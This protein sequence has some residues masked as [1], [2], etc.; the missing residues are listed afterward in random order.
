MLNP[1]PPS[2]LAWLIPVNPQSTTAFRSAARCGCGRCPLASTTSSKGTST[3]SRKRRALSCSAAS[4]ALRLRSIPGLRLSWRI[5]GSHRKR[6]DGDTA[7]FRDDQR[8]DI[9]LCDVVAEIEGKVG[10]SRKGVRKRVHIAGWPATK[11]FQE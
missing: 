8:I 6:V 7:C 11:A 10:Q 3:V 9:Q 5:G 1:H 4:S 2:M